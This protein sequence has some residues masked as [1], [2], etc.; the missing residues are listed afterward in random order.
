MVR[1]LTVM[2]FDAPIQDIGRMPNEPSNKRMTCRDPKSKLLLEGRSHSTQHAFDQLHAH[3]GVA[4]GLRV[5]LRGVLPHDLIES[6]NTQI[7]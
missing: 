1:T 3:L 7:P 4:I 2:P 5:V 6:L